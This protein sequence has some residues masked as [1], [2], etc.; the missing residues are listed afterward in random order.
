[1]CA[2]SVAQSCPTHCD[3]MDR[4]AWQGPATGLSKASTLEWVATSYSRR[5]S[6]TGDQTHISCICRKILYH[7]HHLG[8]PK[9][10]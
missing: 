10:R 8:N 7:Y 1:M 4:G 9:I 3:H 6:R 2:C 5:S